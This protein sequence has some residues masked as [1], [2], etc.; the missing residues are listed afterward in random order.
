MRGMAIRPVNPLKA[1]SMV[2][3]GPDH[4]EDEFVV[5]HF[6]KDHRGRHKAGNLRALS[7]TQDDRDGGDDRGNHDEDDGKTS[8]DRSLN[9]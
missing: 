7:Q 9:D 8:G 5:T 1:T 6:S 3:H 2:G 4:D